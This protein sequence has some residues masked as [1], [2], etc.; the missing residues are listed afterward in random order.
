MLLRLALGEGAL[1]LHTTLFFSTPPLLRQGLPYLWGKTLRHRQ[2]LLLE[3]E[4]FFP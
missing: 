2:V 1:R 4:G 3:G